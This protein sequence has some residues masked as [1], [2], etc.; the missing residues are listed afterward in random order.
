[1]VTTPFSFFATV[2]AIVRVGAMPRFADIE[3]ATMNL[4]MSRVAEA[5]TERTRAVLVVHLFGRAANV[6]QLCELASEFGIAVVED[7]AQ[8]FGV[9]HGERPLGTWG[10]LGCFSFFPS[11]PLGAF[12]DAGLVATRDPEL[13]DRCRRLRVHGAA[14]KHEHV[15]VGGNFRLDAL[16]AAVLGV[17]LAFLDRW[18]SRRR[19][20]AAAYTDAFGDIDDLAVP[21]GPLG[22]MPVSNYTIRVHSGQRDALAMFLRQRNIETAVYYPRPLHLQPALAYLGLREGQFPVAEKAA[23]EVLTLPLYPELTETQR[24]YVIDGVRAFYEKGAAHA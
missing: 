24:A 6:E 23:R 4:D 17:K 9:T 15:E 3:P 11:K 1:V 14:A 16:Q 10:A 18:M 13:A 21:R 19:E 22:T 8:A 2:G 5:V 12:G 20:H 7:A